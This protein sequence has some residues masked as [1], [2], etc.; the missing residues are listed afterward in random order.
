MKNIIKYLA[1]KKTH[2]VV[3]MI[4]LFNALIIGG[5]ISPDPSHVEAINYILAATGLTT[6]RIGVSNSKK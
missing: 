2:I 4:V 5:V 6:L 1:G 3:A